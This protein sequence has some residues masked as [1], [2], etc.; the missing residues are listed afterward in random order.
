MDAHLFA[1][2]AVNRFNN[3]LHDEVFNFI[4]ETPEL[5]ALYQ[6]AEQRYSRR[7][8]D[9]V[10]ND[11]LVEGL[12]QHKPIF[13][14][15][16]PEYALAEETLV[17]VANEFIAQLT[18]RVFLSLE[19]DRELMRMLIE[20]PDSLPAVE[21]NICEELMDLY[22]VLPTGVEEHNPKSNMLN[23][24]RRMMLKADEEI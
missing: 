23:S 2:I 5:S 18:D 19:H 22:F 24:Y 21:E 15:D 20:N 14:T 4:K 3:K 1:T 17:K 16:D 11:F 6:K 12:I 7:V 9:N 8:I 13:F 10:L